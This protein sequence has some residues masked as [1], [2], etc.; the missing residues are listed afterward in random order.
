MKQSSRNFINLSTKRNCQI[1][2]IIN[3]LAILR[4][5][6]VTFDGS[7]WNLSTLLKILSLDDDTK[8]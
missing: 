8:K 6:L 3:N 5:L 2:K 4:G 7:S 1:L